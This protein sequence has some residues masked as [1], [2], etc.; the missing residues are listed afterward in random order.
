[1]SRNF[2]L[3]REVAERKI[4][5]EHLLIPISHND[6]ELGALYN[7]PNETASFIWDAAKAGR[8]ENEIV[9]QLQETFDVGETTATS[10]VAALLDE[11]IAQNL[12]QET[13]AKV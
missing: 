1:M 11:L 8:S 7:L 5:G 12:L 6:E 2:I 4:R 3:T 10:D 9:A 13:P